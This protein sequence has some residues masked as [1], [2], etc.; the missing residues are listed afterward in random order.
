MVAAFL[1]TQLIC[2]IYICTAHPRYNDY[3]LEIYETRGADDEPTPNRNKHRNKSLC[4]W[5]GT[6]QKEPKNSLASRM[7]LFALCNVL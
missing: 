6:P 7:A 4:I 2:I 5:V 3:E 1:I